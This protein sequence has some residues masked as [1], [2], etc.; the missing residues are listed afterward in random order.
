MLSSKLTTRKSS[1]PLYFALPY[2]I[3]NNALPSFFALQLRSSD[4]PPAGESQLLSTLGGEFVTVMRDEAGDVIVTSSVGEAREGGL[5][6]SLR[7]HEEEGETR[8]YEG[9]IGMSMEAKI[10][11]SWL[12]SQPYG[13]V[14]S[15]LK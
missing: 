14:E 10:R 8:I 5:I 11:S 3:C 9:K 1:Q 13:G 7:R 15:R 12:S 4:L 6:S 2:C